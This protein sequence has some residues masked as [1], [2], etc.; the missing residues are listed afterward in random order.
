MFQLTE[1]TKAKLKKAEDKG[2]KVGQKDIRN[3]TLITL[4]HT[5]PN[6]ALEMFDPE[7]RPILYGKGNPGAKGRKQAQLEGVDMVEDL[8]AL[9][10]TGAALATLNWGKEQPG[11]SMIVKYGVGDGRSDITF[12]D[13]T[14]Q[15]VKLSLL[16]GGAVKVRYK[17][18]APVDHLS[19]EQLGKLHKMHQREVTITLTGPQVDDRQADIEDGDQGGE[20][21]TPPAAGKRKRGA[22]AL[23]PIG[24]LKK[25]QKNAS[26]AKGE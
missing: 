14:V 26:G 2:I 15:D 18:H 21:V 10:Q 6:T 20:T 4:E 1:P 3:A 24:A 13:G 11:C 17:F 9:T 25:A 8:P 22:G 5:L 16:E 7:L 23:T 12:S 19:D